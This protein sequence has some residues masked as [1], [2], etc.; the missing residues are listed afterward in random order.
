ME[1][2]EQITDQ[3]FAHTKGKTVGNVGVIATDNGNY[4]IDT[5]MFPVI[6]R[7]IRTEI[8]SIKTGKLLG[9]ILTHY[10]LDHT[11]GNQ[12]FHPHIH[13]HVKVLE[14]MKSSYKQEEIIKSLEQREDKQLFDG[15]TITYPTHTFETNP[16]HPDESDTI[17]VYRVGG[18]TNGSSLI[19]Y[20]EEAAL[21]AGDD[22]FAGLFPWGGDPTASPYDWL[23]ATEMMINLDPKIIIPGHGEVQYNMQEVNKL[24][25]YLS[26]VIQTG[27]ESI[28][29][30][31]P[32]EKVIEDLMDIDFNPARNPDMKERTLDQWYS[33]IKES[34]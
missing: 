34:S 29:D 20:K 6:A 33:I 13:S 7:D 30:A 10:H 28:K 31:S 22:L 5:S 17:E 8:Q 12:H 27:E 3:I 9:A 24:H 15:M 26:N 21:F 18:H 23:A 4:I 14:N 32:K 11:A 16:Y 25:E 2:L 19:Y 1:Y